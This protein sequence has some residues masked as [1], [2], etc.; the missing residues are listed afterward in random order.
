MEWRFLLDANVHNVLRGGVPAEAIASMVVVHV[1]TQDDDTRSTCACAES[2][3]FTYLSGRSEKP[4]VS[5]WL[6]MRLYDCR[7]TTSGMKS[8]AIRSGSQPAT[9][10][11]TIHLPRS[12]SKSLAASSV[13]ELS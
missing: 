10:C 11:A 6:Q 1:T 2:I 9:T 5:H 12:Y 8:T 3:S 7:A 4:P 13:V